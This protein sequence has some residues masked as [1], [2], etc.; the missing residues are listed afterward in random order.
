M[1]SSHTQRVLVD[2]L[3]ADGGFAGL[4]LA[5]VFGKGHL[6]VVQYDFRGSVLQG[7]FLKVWSGQC[8]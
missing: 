1:V 7:F 6:P 3:N 5:C 8:S 4:R 2:H